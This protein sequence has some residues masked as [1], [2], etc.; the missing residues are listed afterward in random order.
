MMRRPAVG[1]SPIPRANAGI[2]STS[3]GRGLVTHLAGQGGDVLRRLGPALFTLTAG[4]GGDALYCLGP[5]S[6]T[7]TAG[8]GGDM[9]H[10]LGPAL[11]I[12]LRARAETYSTALALHQ[13]LI[14][15]P[16]RQTLS[17]PWP[18]ILANCKRQGGQLLPPWPRTA[19][20]SAVRPP[21]T[22]GQG[23]VILYRLGHAFS[24]DDEGVGEDAL[25]DGYLVDSLPSA[26]RMRHRGGGCLPKDASTTA[27]HCAFRLHCLWAVQ[28]F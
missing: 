26:S 22:P 9:F 19:I 14:S 8:Q 21:P 15:G 5:A 25:G 23:G 13:S 20:V 10:R 16:R 17:P 3:L 2:S 7:H 11:V 27:F 1:R 24:K 18:R 4:Q 12:R 6:V 28:I